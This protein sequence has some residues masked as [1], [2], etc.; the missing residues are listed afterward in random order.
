MGRMYNEQLTLGTHLL[1]CATILGQETNKLRNNLRN[2]Y[3]FKEN[4]MKKTH[5][6]SLV[7]TL[8]AVNMAFAA[9]EIH[10]TVTGQNSVTFD[11]RGTAT[12]KTLGYGVTSGVY[13]QVT[14]TTPNPVPVSSSGPFWEAKLTGLKENTRYYY[15]IGSGT[16]RSFRTPP[17]PGSSDFTV[18]AEGNIGSSSTYFN[19]G[20]VQDLIAN[21]LPAFVVGLGDLTLGNN[22]GKVN[23]DQHFNDVMVWSKEAAYMPVWGEMDTVT[24]KKAQDNFKNYKG[25]FAV[26]NSQTSPGS[27]LAGGEDWY[28]FDYGNVRFITMPE[29]WKG[30]WAD[31][32]T[33]AGKLMAQAQADAN[34]K[35]IVTFVHQPAYSSGHYAGSATLKGILDTLGDT[36]SKYKLNINA[37]SNNYERSLPQH[38]VTHVTAGTGGANLTQDGNC[39]WLACTKPAWSAFRAMHLGALKLHFTDSGI[40]GSFIC[41]PAGGGKNDVTCKTGSIVDSFSIGDLAPKP[42]PITNFVD[43][44]GALDI[45]QNIYKLHESL[46]QGVPLGYDWAKGPRIGDGNDP[47]TN[48]ATTGWAQIFWADGVKSS[49]DNVQIRNLQF[50]VCH[51]AEHKWTLLQ[52]GEIEGEQFT[53]DFV[54]NVSKSASFLTQ[55]DGVATVAFEPG[56]VFHFWPKQGQV[57][58]PSEPICGFL[59]LLEARVVPG[60]GATSVTPGAFLIGLGADYWTKLNSTWDNFNT[61]SDIEVGRLKLV[62]ADWAWYGMST[63]SDDD[64]KAI[65]QK[66]FDL[67]PDA[68]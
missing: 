37:H 45:N 54:N 57:S 67:S 36:Y 66:G 61:N 30:A 18:Y 55:K 3:I 16:E 7:T 51:G 42:K 44:A 6:L 21:D 9:D 31:W 8:L 39:L 35:F 15:K 27:P 60:P 43:L 11:W 20:T 59:A 58:L 22:N 68:D 4:I 64:L 33:K 52:R 2:A 50:L 41:G 63:T 25:R 23:I 1:E 53:S 34:I 10:W 48:A 26:P 5:F 46:P 47:G 40:E 32:N 28:W 24:S 56:S 65:Y 14:A 13:T 12:E 49:T 17:A 19:T 29:Q 62:G 38:G